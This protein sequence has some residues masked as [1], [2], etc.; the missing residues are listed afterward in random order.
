MSAF[1]AVIGQGGVVL[2]PSDTVYGLACD[3]TSQTAIE[4]L[5]ALKGRPPD[6]AAA[7]MFFDLE[8]ALDAL[9]ELGPNTRRALEALMPG[10][11]TA[12]LPNPAQRFALSARADPQTL[13]LRVVSVPALA[14]VQV[15]VLQSSANLSGG[16]DARRLSE[17]AP[18]IRAGADLVIDGG[19]LP[20]VAS[21]VVDLRAYEQEGVWSV[22]RL[23]AVDE[24]ELARRLGGR[25][26]FE[27]GTY[28]AMVSD[29]LPGYE[30]LQAQVALAAGQ[31]AQ[32]ILELG[33]GTGETAAR[34]L[35]QNPLAQITGV[36]ESPAM[37]AAA[38][39]R[40][41]ERL[42]A[43]H[44]GLLQEPL[45]EGRFDLVVSAL[46]V[47]HL[48]P[49]EKAL[50]FSR[51]RERLAPD[52]RF[53]LGDV[54]VPESPDEAVVALTDGYD[55]PSSVAEQLGWLRAA[56]FEARVSWTLRDLAVLVARPL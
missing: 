52:G 30:Q 31:G 43:A 37:L 33:I 3:P 16:A 56:G 14:G 35:E 2:F 11:V 40:L 48:D 38:A 42:V 23:G 6:K 8:A 9:G 50:L 12:L 18:A 28:A 44:V 4:R 22:R 34:L 36:D 21:T 39:A 51:V 46:A 41:G 45:P 20:G 55:K 10:A 27:P 26:R 1:E 15:P 19:E 29:T 24:D 47:H 49:D 13:G 54:V 7:I 53:V 25:F 32:T 5:Y 17:V